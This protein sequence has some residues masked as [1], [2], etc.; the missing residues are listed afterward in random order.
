[1]GWVRVK[2]D[3]LAELEEK[4]RLRDTAQYIQQYIQFQSILQ[5]IVVVWHFNITTIIVII[6]TTQFEKTSENHPLQW[7]T[8]LWNKVDQRW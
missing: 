2:W 3:A 4:K 6:I 5:G 7:F 8:A 1:M